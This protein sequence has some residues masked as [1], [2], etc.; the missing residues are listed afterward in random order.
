MK[1]AFKLIIAITFI[2]FVLLGLYLYVEISHTNEWVI[3]DETRRLNLFCK[4]IHQ[5]IENSMLDKKIGEIEKFIKKL[6][7]NIG[8]NEITILNSNQEVK[9]IAK[10][11]N[12]DLR[13][14]FVYFVPIFNKKE[15]FKCHKN[16][17]P[18]LGYIRISKSITP[19]LLR[20]KK[21]LKIHIYSFFAIV[22]ITSLLIGLA[23]FFIVNTP[24]KVLLDA[25]K[26]VEKGVTKKRLS[27]SRNDEFGVISKQFNS[28]L[29]AL[30]N[31][32]E[33]IVRLQ[34]EKINRV[35][36]MVLVGQIAAG[37]AHQMKTPLASAMLRAE[38]LMEDIKNK[39]YLGELKFINHQ[40]QRC[41]E[42]VEHLL[43]FSRSTKA[44]EK[45]QECNFNKV[46][47]DIIEILSH[48]F[49]KNDVSLK[50]DVAETDKVKVLASCDQLEQIFLNLFS[51]SFDAIEK[52]GTISVKTKVIDNNFIEVDFT[53]DGSGISK[54]NLNEIF[55]PFFTTKEAKNGTGLGLA[56]CR[57]LIEE[58]RGTITVASE[59]NK[60]TTFTI[61][62]PILK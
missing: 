34:E 17:K 10:G 30:E 28:M 23:I 31:S 40:L 2:L 8:F 49:R 60:Y 22:I 52:G 53:D 36:K 54:E 7:L 45:L 14:N 35:D 50:I 32:Q 55:E 1:I 12:I 61:S 42:I 62:F 9:I 43:G 41:K 13:D 51:N 58:L 38:M 3:D 5:Q 37:I 48:I 21:E 56:I 27:V 47:T 6:V 11:V 26:Q 16:T 4:T 33:E 57:K 19:A 44:K 29:N 46:L 15:C 24:I 18:V 39:S 59:V 25:M 20:V